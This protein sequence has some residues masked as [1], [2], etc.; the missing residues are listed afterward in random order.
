MPEYV[1]SRPFR[2]QLKKSVG[3]NPQTPSP[4]CFTS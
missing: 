1:E 3:A 4:Y 2:A